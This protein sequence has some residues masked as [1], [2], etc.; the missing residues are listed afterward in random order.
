MDENRKRIS[1]RV[2]LAFFCQSLFLV[3]QPALLAATPPGLPGINAHSPFTYLERIERP[4]HFA[5]RVLQGNRDNPEGDFDQINEVL[6]G[7]SIKINETTIDLEADDGGIMSFIDL[8]LQFDATQL[9]EDLLLDTVIDI[10]QNALRYAGRRR[11]RRQLDEQESSLCPAYGSDT[12][13]GGTFSSGGE[14]LLALVANNLQLVFGD[15][16]N[17]LLEDFPVEIDDTCLSLDSLSGGADVTE[18]EMG[19]IMNGGTLDGM[20]EADLVMRF[21]QELSDFLQDTLVIE[22]DDFFRRQKED[23]LGVIFN[24]DLN[25]TNIKCQD[26]TLE[27]LDVGVQNNNDGFGFGG[28]V[29]GGFGGFNFDN[30]ILA[31][32][33][34]ATCSGYAT[35]GLGTLL[36]ESAF[37]VKLV[38]DSIALDLNVAG[39][40]LTVNFCF[41]TVQVEEVEFTDTKLLSFE[42]SDDVVNK[43]YDT[44]GDVIEDALEDAVNPGKNDQL[45]LFTSQPSSTSCFDR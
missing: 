34:R 38:G 17:S 39:D 2:K 28:G 35:F 13:G 22:V 29:G 21:G 25:V 31:N 16:I 18:D 44:V 20:M 23:V 6:S 14:N 15:E 24:F 41:A 30:S 19:M 3:G 11:N 26:F 10:P 40:A 27:S 8:N 9:V 37:E 43:I 7:I 1:Q 33:L 5:N 42:L 32:K 45:F 4:K 12:D 36:V